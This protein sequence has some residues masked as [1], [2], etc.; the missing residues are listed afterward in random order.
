MTQKYSDQVINWWIKQNFRRFIWVPVLVS[1]LLA[2][3][4]V[5]SMNLLLFGH[6]DRWYMLI[7]LVTSGAVSIIVVALLMVMSDR[8]RVSEIRFR[9][10]S[11][12]NNDLVYSCRCDDNGLLK[13]DWISG[14]A[15]PIFGYTNLELMGRGF[16]QC[17]VIEEDL[18]IFSKCISEPD[19]GAI[20]ENILRIKH[21]DGSVHFLHS[22]T[23]FETGSGNKKPRLYGVLQD[24]T[25]QKQ[26]EDALHKSVKLFKA[27]TGS[28]P[29]AI[30]VSEGVEQRYSYIN[31]TAIKLFGYRPAE[32]EQVADWWPLAYPDPAYRHWVSEE[33]TQRVEKAVVTHTAIEP[34]EVVVTCKDGSRKNILW[35]F[36]SIGE[37]NV[38]YGLDL[39]EHRRQ[40]R[41]LENHRL[42]LEDMVR[43]KTDE[44]LEA[45]ILAEAGSRAKSDF[46]ANMSHEL[47]TPMNAIIGMSHLLLDSD[48]NPRQ[49]DYLL[50]IQKS[51]QH[52]LDMVNDVLDFSKIEAG[53][54]N[55]DRAPFKLDRLLDDVAAL[56]TDKAAG[57]HLALSFTVEPDVPHHLVGDFTKLKQ[58]L[59]NLLSNAIKFTPEG[60]INVGVRLAPD[61]V[62]GLRLSFSVR[63][64]GIGISREQ[65]GR[66]FQSFQQADSSTTRRYGGTGLGLA[67]SKRLVELME[68]EIGVSSEPGLGSTFWFTVRLE[69][70]SGAAATLQPIAA[71]GQ[72][73][74][75]E[76][77][78]AI[79]GARVLVA[80]DNPLNQEM[81]RVLIN[82]AGLTI[83]IVGDGAAALQLLQ[84]R[85]PDDYALIMM[86]MH[87]PE[88]DGATASRAIRRLPGW[89]ARP[90]VGITANVSPVERSAGLRAGMNDVI[91]KP[92]T[93][94]ALYPT[95][96]RWIAPRPLPPISVVNSEELARVFGVLA[97][98]LAGHELR[99]KHTL[100][101]HARLLQ[102]AS[103]QTFEEIKAALEDID[104]E[105]ALTVLTVM[106]RS[107]QSPHG[108]IGAKQQQP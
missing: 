99:A 70:D 22:R 56:N 79:A 88:M 26:A 57:K 64:T 12:M 58:I 103:P 102:T 98:Q 68:G 85:A 23:Q 60:E 91:D 18:P 16:W 71:S 83:D 65:I 43:E 106:T 61:T 4:I 72:V 63:D 101:N 45:K 2:E 46:L 107:L 76:L 35:G 6:V 96:L 19:S 51:S 74:D 31:P 92:V 5:A 37:Q 89:A 7:G 87:M 44:L 93:P 14:K 21:R 100:E 36:A 94:A 73:P 3:A 25:K 24:I 41:E 53:Q 86:D 48:Q 11:S 34:M 69:R 40:E 1:I 66:L 28:S 78:S 20:S 32:I 62:S 75:L 80:D 54:M 82:Q 47:R 33:W 84:G 17:F 27:I 38:A 30:F 9:H 50:K 95:L 90:I 13:F 10:I 8:I 15:K 49:R 77:L 97:Q 105:R 81:L 52:L 42:H 39:T 59:I 108:M 29:L 67:I 55:L 104:F